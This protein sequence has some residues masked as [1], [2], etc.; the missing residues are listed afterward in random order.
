MI[1][2]VQTAPPPNKPAV[3]HLYL[4]EDSPHHQWCGFA[5]KKDW[6]AWL[7]DEKNYSLANAIVDFT[8]ARI[9][10]IK[11]QWEAE[12]GDSATIDT[13][14]LTGGTIRTLQRRT[15]VLPGDTAKFQTY[16][17]TNGKA[18]LQSTELRQLSTG[19]LI[20]RSDALIFQQ[21][22][23]TR[24][25]GFPFSPLFDAQHLS[26]IRAKKPTCIAVQQ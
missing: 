18:R 23:V 20:S 13:Y 19:K 21:E 14:H 4:L 5:T 6:N 26:D 24:P 12:S 7:S 3:T 25:D 15:N 9:S 8:G 11:I 17:I 1:F 16:V 2:L 10:V 22:V